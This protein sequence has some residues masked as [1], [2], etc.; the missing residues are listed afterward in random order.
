MIV[1]SLL[2]LLLTK[3]LHFELHAHSLTKNHAKVFDGMAGEC[4]EGE[5]T[6]SGYQL[7]AN[8]CQAFPAVSVPSVHRMSPTTFS[9]LGSPT[10]CLRY[11]IRNVDAWW[12]N[13]SW[14]HFTNKLIIP[15]PPNERIVELTPADEGLAIAQVPTPE[16]PLALM[17]F[18]SSYIARRSG[19]RMERLSLD[20]KPVGNVFFDETDSLKL[21]AIYDAQFSSDRILVLGF[22]IEHGS[23]F[24][25]YITGEVRS[26]SN[27]DVRISKLRA[28]LRQRDTRM[29][30]TGHA[31]I[32][33]AGDFFYFLSFDDVPT[34]RRL[35]RADAEPTNLLT[36]SLGL[37]RLPDV[38]VDGQGGQLRF[39]A[40][41]NSLHLPISL[42]ADEGQLFLLVRAPAANDQTRWVLH[43][44]ATDGSPQ[45][46]YT[47]P[48]S[49]AQILAFPD[50]D[51]WLLFEKGDVKQWGLQEIAGALRI[52]KAWLRPGPG[53]PLLNENSARDVCPTA[54]NQS[55]GPPASSRLPSQRVTLRRHSIW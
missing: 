24:T 36:R 6:C 34:L 25:G 26:L 5:G 3:M 17:L 38:A 23:K 2:F 30:R 33:H 1:R 14:L 21:L 40:E 45:V 52:P 53:S 51:H 49:A 19:V 39:T 9:A 16:K 46:E 22:G 31:C 15:D 42:L 27:G 32:A 47:L 50:G 4:V 11:Q 10:G 55:L 44:F 8:S 28:V 12:N 41:L 20:L 18:Q 29:A 35:G 43:S 48:T 54:P 37:S 13:G 7:L